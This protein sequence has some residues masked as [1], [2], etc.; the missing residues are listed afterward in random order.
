MSLQEDLHEANLEIARLRE[1]LA[2]RPLDEGKVYRFETGSTPTGQMTL[3]VTA[4]SYA[5]EAKVAELVA[6]Y[7]NLLFNL[8]EPRVP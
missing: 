7:V 2:E 5:T 4:P 3:I 1:L 6:G 8:A